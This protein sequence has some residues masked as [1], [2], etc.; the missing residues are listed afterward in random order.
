MA[1]TLLLTSIGVK[2]WSDGNETGEKKVYSP[3]DAMRLS[4]R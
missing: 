2:G 1:A 3:N 4:G